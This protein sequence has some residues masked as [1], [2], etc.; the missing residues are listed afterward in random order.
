MLNLSPDIEECLIEKARDE[1]LS[2][3]DYLRQLLKTPPLPPLTRRVAGLNRGEYWMSDD[4]N[5]PLPDAFWLG[6]E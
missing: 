3:E 6:E 2:V 4:F 5:A 1:S